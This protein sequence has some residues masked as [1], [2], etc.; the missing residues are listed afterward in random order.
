MESI[1]Y[2]F[3]QF[4]QWWKDL[5][6]DAKA[7]VDDLHIAFA[8]AQRNLED[9]SHYIHPAFLPIILFTIAVALLMKFWSKGAHHG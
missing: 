2:Q 3:H 9:I 4:I 7:T 5:Y 1:F 8:R 6:F